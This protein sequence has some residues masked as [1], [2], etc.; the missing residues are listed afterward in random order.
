MQ[1]KTYVSA[2]TAYNKQQQHDTGALA[3]AYLFM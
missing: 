2:L 1:H 3:Y